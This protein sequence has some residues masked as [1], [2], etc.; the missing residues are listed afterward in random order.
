MPQMN[1]ID[2]VIGITTIVLMKLQYKIFHLLLLADAA[3]DIP[4]V[5]DIQNGSPNYL[6]FCSDM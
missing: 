3:I 5:L 2:R 1:V 6:I 4:F